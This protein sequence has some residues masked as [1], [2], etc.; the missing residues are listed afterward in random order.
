M[1]NNIQSKRLSRSAAARVLGV[2]SETI[3]FY[4]QTGRLSFVL[5]ASGHREYDGLEVHRLAKLRRRAAKLRK[6]SQR[7]IAVG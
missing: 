2:S 4:S 5:N 6:K 1:A 3:W 7:Q